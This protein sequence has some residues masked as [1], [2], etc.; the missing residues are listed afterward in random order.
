MA[1]TNVKKEWVDSILERLD[2]TVSR[3]PVTK[4]EDNI[5][6]SET[7][8]N[9]SAA[10][11]QAVFIRTGQGFDYN[12][13]GLEEGGDA[14]AMVKDDVTLN[15]DDTLTVNS[16][17]YRVGTVITYYTDNDNAV[18]VYKYATLFLIT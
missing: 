2:R 8:T 9:G 1:I 16:L 18:A 4:T 7:L 12:K 5:T 13:A 15:K 14:Y 11:I 6:G 3:T 10:N 17:V